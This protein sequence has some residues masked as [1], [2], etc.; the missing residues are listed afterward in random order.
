MALSSILQGDTFE[1]TAM[2]KVKERRQGAQNCVVNKGMVLPA[3]SRYEK[4]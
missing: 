4:A 3:T 2:I 1:N